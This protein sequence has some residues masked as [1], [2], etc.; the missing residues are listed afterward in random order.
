MTK[1]TFL[2]GPILPALIKFSFPILLALVIQ[3]LYGAVDLW[4]SE[5]SAVKPMY[6]LLQRAARQ[7]RL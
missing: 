7:C 2:K 4:P 6:R 3:A 5:H 1:H